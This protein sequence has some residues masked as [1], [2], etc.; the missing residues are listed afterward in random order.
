[1]LDPFFPPGRYAY[2]KANFLKD[3]S[4]EAMDVFSA[5]ATAPSPY[6]SGVLEQLGGAFARVPSTETA[7]AHRNYPYN[8]SIWSN[9][10]DRAESEKTFAGAGSSGTRCTLLAS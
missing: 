7:F 10:V 9:W 5:Y 6:T 2:T 8:F 1:M 4:P 3:L